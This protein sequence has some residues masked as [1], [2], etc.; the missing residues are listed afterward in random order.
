MIPSDTMYYQRKHLYLERF[1]TKITIASS[2]HLYYVDFGKAFGIYRKYILFY[3]IM[4]SE[5]WVTNAK[6]QLTKNYKL[7]LKSLRPSNAYMRR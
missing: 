1:S 7:L 3:K 4:K 5:A 6:R 2:L